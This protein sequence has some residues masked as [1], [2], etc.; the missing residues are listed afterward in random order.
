MGTILGYSYCQELDSQEFMRHAERV[1]SLEQNFNKLL[2]GRLD[3]VVEVDSVGLY[4]A[5]K[6][7]IADK[8]S[9]IPDAKYCQG[10]NYLAF[11]KKAN[12]ENLTLEFNNALEDFKTTNEYHAILKHYGITNRL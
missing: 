4:T 10:G 1:S 7:G 2:A 12:Y 3:L 5:N 6:M 9:I 11:S 8:V